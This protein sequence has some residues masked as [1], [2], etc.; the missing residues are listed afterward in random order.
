MPECLSKSRNACSKPTEWSQ[1]LRSSACLLSKLE[2]EMKM[3]AIDLSRTSGRI[4][5][6][7]AAAPGVWR[8]ERQIN[9]RTGT[10]Q[11]IVHVSANFNGSGANSMDG[12]ETECRRSLADQAATTAVHISGAVLLSARS[13]PNANWPFLIRCMSSIPAIVIDAR[14]NRLNPSMGPNRS[15]MDRWSCS[16]RLLKYFDDRSLVLLPRPCAARNSLAARCDV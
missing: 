7:R 9:F 3:R 6:N 4:L 5:L 11:S 2:C 16:I 13:L 15:L 14:R 8:R 1:A 10:L 12:R